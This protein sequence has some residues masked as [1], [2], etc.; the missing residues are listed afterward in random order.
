MYLFI[1]PNVYLYIKIDY[2]V[3]K[4][5]NDNNLTKRSFYNIYIILIKL[6]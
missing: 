4:K 3:I 1:L 5:K 6:F 2:N